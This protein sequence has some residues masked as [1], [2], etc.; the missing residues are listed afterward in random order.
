ML[1][2]CQKPYAIVQWK[3]ATHL[4]GK[5]KFNTHNLFDLLIYIDF[6][7]LRVVLYEKFFWIETQWLI[8]YQ[9]SYDRQMSFPTTI[10]PGNLNGI[11]T[12][13]VFAHANNEAV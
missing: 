4:T 13:A 1:G 8:Q 6:W 9:E 12:V 5:W 10:L 7:V 2:T 3:L 11:L